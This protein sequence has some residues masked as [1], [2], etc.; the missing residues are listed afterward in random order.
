MKVDNA[1]VASVFSG[2]NTTRCSGKYAY[3][4]DPTLRRWASSERG[5]KVMDVEVSDRMVRRV[6]NKINHAPAKDQCVIFRYGNPVIIKWIDY[7]RSTAG[8][9]YIVYLKY[10]Y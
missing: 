4:S 9:L 1:K 8:H 7:S 6:V 5:S 10:D 2:P 3:A